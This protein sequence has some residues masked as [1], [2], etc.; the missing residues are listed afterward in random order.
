MCAPPRMPPARSVPP[1]IPPARRSLLMIEWMERP[2]RRLNP[3]TG[4]WI[5]VSPHRAARPW[6][7]QVETAATQAAL[8][9]D[10]L[11]Y[12]C[13]GNERA[14]G[15]RNPKY[16]STFVFE[17]DFPALLMNVPEE[18]SNGSQLLMARSEPGTCRVGCF[19]PNHGLT[20]SRMSVSALREVVDMWA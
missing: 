8:S 7:G 4:D 9:Y 20:I 17:N 19:S 6:Q 3:L 14:G 18:Y 10:P 16:T 13:P 1:R 11:C 12:L 15:K 2:H 5:L